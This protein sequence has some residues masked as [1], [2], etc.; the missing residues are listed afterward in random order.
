[1]HMSKNEYIVK[2]DMGVSLVFETYSEARNYVLAREDR[3][4]CIY[5]RTIHVEIAAEDWVGLPAELQPALNGM[6]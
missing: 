1:M 5:R 4:C 6:L 3:S 2:S